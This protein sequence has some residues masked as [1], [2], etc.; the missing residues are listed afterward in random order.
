MGAVVR[1]DVKK[2]PLYLPYHFSAV[3]ETKGER[4][5][6]KVK[7]VDTLRVRAHAVRPVHPTTYLVDML[8]LVHPTS[9]GSELGE[10]EQPEPRRVSSERPGRRPGAA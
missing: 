5:K 4:A 9:E 1:G 7:S 8:R 10:N 3:L 6:G 2:L